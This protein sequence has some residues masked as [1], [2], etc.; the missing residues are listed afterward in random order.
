MASDT[1]SDSH[2]IEALCMRLLEYPHPD[3][4][5]SVAFSVRQLPESIAADIP[6]PSD[7]RVLGS[8]L[9]SHRGRPA[10]MEAVIDA[11]ISF[12]EL[13]APFQRAL[14]ASGWSVLELDWSNARRLRLE[15]PR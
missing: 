4:P 13:V 1:D 11:P 3:G 14:N 10:R 8:A 2:G 12:A 5:T 15:R 9:Y 6:I 7:W